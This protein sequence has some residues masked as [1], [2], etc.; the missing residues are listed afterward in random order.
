MVVSSVKKKNI[1]I[2]VQFRQIKLSRVKNI[3]LK[4][5]FYSITQVLLD[6]VRLLQ[7]KIAH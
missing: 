6:H 2:R 3:I 7:L 5:S 1:K 4:F